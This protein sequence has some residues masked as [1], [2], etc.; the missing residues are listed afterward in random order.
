VERAVPARL[1]KR[2]GSFDELRTGVP[3]YQI[4][5]VIRLSIAALLLLEYLRSPQNLR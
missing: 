4:L 5:A 1:N 2:A 3:L